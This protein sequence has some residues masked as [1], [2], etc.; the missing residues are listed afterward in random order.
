MKHVVNHDISD[1]A[2]HLALIARRRSRNRRLRRGKR[3]PAWHLETSWNILKPPKTWQMIDRMFKLNDWTL[4]EVEDK[5]VKRDIY[6]SLLRERRNSMAQA[7][8]ARLCSRWKF[9]GQCHICHICHMGSLFSLETS[10]N[11]RDVSVIL[12]FLTGKIID[13][14]QVWWPESMD[15][16]KAMVSPQDS[17]VTVGPWDRPLLDSLWIL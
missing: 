14:P 1:I 5:Q 6:I 9:F 3:S 16:R 12:F 4:Q 17:A 11:W 2:A 10:P 15:R 7:G 13:F 8:N